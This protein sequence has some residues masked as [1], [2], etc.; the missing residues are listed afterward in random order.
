MVSEAS[1]GGIRQVGVIGKERG[2]F[3]SHV[4]FDLR[5]DEKLIATDWQMT[6]DVADC[7]DDDDRFA[8]TSIH[9]EQ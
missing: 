1:D 7:D 9:A 4:L 8:L 2:G 5:G 6:A 3:I